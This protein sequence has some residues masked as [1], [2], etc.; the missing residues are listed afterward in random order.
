M[1]GQ[2]QTNTGSTTDQLVRTM[3]DEAEHGVES[4]MP[5]EKTTSAS[6]YIASRA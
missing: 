3:H 1:Q 2:T 6:T 4:G 5:P